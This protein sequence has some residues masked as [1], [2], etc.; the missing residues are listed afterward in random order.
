MQQTMAGFRAE[1]QQDQEESVERAA[2]KAR[3]AAEVTFRCKGNEKQYRFN[4]AIQEKMSAPALR[5]EVCFCSSQAATSAISSASF[6]RTPG[7]VMS[8]EQARTAVQEGMEL[9]KSCQKTIRLADRSNLDW[10]VVNEYG[11][12]KLADNLDDKKRM[13]R[14]VAAAEKKTAQ[15]KKTGRGAM[16]QSRPDVA[17]RPPRPTDDSGYQVSRMSWHVGP[18]FGCGEMGHLKRNCPKTTTPRLY[19]FDSSVSIYDLSNVLLND[20][21]TDRGSSDL[22][23]MLYELSEELSLDRDPDH[24]L[25]LQSEVEGYIWVADGQSLQVQGRL[26]RHV[27][28]WEEVLHPLEYILNSIRDGYVLLLFSAPTPY[29]RHNHSSALEKK[30]SVTEAVLDLLA[31]NCI[32]KVSEKPFICSPLSVVDGPSKKRLV[33][34]LRHLNSFLWK[35]RFKY[36]DLRTALL[37]FEKGDMAFTFDLKSRYHHVDIHQSCWKYLGF[38]W[39]IDGKE[40]YYVFK[41]LLFGL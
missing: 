29:I 22:S 16:M 39:D 25:H 3:L 41:I 12:D 21:G 36:E 26:K 11:E 15:Q 19:P 7:L 8:L 1:L 18:C 30:D 5:F 17:F 13:A 31:N 4:E 23:T 33:I 28:Y 38:R 6:L 40:T 10:A 14:A 2:K 27:V 35:Q 34:N 9:L 24:E 37:L 32:I 20:E